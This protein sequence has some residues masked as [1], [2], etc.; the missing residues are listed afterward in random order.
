MKTQEDSFWSSVEKDVG[1]IPS[2][3]KTILKHTGFINGALAEL[4]DQECD[5]IEHDMRRMRIGMSAELDECFRRFSYRP[6]H[7]CLMT[8]ERTE[9]KLIARTIKKNGIQRYLKKPRSTSGSLSLIPT[10]QH[11]SADGEN[12]VLKEKIIEFYERRFDGSVAQRRIVDSI[13]TFSV[14]VSV[15]SAGLLAKISCSLCDPRRT[16]TCR[17][18]SSGRWKISNVISHITHVHKIVFSPPPLPCGSATAC[19]RSSLGKKDLSPADKI[20]RL[21][22]AADTGENEMKIERTS[23]HRLV[24]VEY[25]DEYEEMVRMSETSPAAEGSAEG[26][27]EIEADVPHDEATAMPSEEDPL[28]F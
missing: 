1:I 15:G 20:I 9:L 26:E 11:T 14:E 16:I 23:Q 6:E 28:N 13:Q 27:A 22:N 2:N 21:D 17:T 12:S 19:K 18:E 24:S 5:G 7:F 4:G 25:L 8:G 3:L 10:A